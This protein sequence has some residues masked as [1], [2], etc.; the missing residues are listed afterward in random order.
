MVEIREEQSFSVLPRLRHEEPACK[1]QK[2]KGRNR[3]SIHNPKKLKELAEILQRLGVPNT[4]PAV[5][6]EIKVF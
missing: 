5:E 1:I 6:V 3:K 2:P 4:I